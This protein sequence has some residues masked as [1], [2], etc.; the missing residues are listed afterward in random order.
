[1]TQTG[2]EI[3]KI[4]LGDDRNLD[5]RVNGIRIEVLAG[6][7][8]IVHT[9]GD[10]R[11]FPQE[12]PDCKDNQCQEIEVSAVM[13]DGVEVGDVMQ[14][15]TIFAGISPDTGEAMYVT[16][17]DAPGGLRMKQAVA[18]VTELS[19]QEAHGHKDWR[20]PTKAELNVMF[21][22]KHKGAL[23]DTFNESSSLISGW[24]TTSEKVSRGRYTGWIQNFHTGQSNWGY[25]GVENSVRPVRSAPR[26][27]LN[28]S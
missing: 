1:M 22:N 4:D 2:D 19:D 12:L 13:Q 27:D 8:I 3:R 5:I 6:Q 14:D 9:D 21:K 28:I 7:G 10:V 11:V 18:Y 25:K 17:A 24:Y 26:P 16:P 20:L 15:G 23:K